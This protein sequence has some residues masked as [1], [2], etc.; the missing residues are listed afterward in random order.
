MIETKLAR[1]LAPPGEPGGPRAGCLDEAALAA[2][3]DGGLPR[4]ERARL[5][6]HLADCEWC[7]RRLSLLA[8]LVREEASREPLPEIAATARRPVDGP[9]RERGPVRWA[10]AAAVIALFSGGLGW[11]LAEM[12]HRPAESPR[13][14][15]SQRVVDEHTGI[16]LLAPVGKTLSLDSRRLVQWSA[17][18]ES[19]FYSV[20]LA[21]S[22]GTPLWEGESR[23]TEIRLPGSLALESGATYYLQVRAHLADGRTVRSGHIE[24]EL[25]ER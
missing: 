9:R 11:R 5:E 14:R 17:V 10:A 2:L 24:L 23:R 8:S 18:P 3:V 19:S 6:G 20:T 7:V 1:I 15:Q 13:V 21:A 4:G 25:G 12:S 16:D 22:D